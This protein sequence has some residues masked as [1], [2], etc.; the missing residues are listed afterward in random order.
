MAR[1]KANSKN[2]IGSI[3][4]RI[5]DKFD[6]TA[7]NNRRRLAGLGLLA[8]ALFMFLTLFTGN[9]GFV[10]ITELHLEKRSLAKENHKLLIELI[11]ADLTVNRLKT[12]PRYI[13]H[14]ARTRHFMSRP[15][16][17]IYRFK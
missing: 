13:E 14:I 15:G 2:I 5:F 1:D 7:L 9:T 4:Q 3:R 8:F 16:E 6:N 10:R 11:D 17:V 12:D